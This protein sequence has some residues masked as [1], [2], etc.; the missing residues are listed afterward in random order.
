MT[1]AYF[2]ETQKFR[3][4]WIWLIILLTVVSWGYAL[5]SSLQAEKP[6]KA[7][8]DLVL[9]LTS[10]IP[11]MLILLIL[12]LRLVTRIRKEGIYIQFK[13]LQV[14]EKFIPKEQIKSFEVRKYKPLAEYGGWGIRAGLRKYGKAYNVSG[15]MGL[16]L[17]LE[18]GKKLLI[19]TQKP[20]EIQKAME[21]LLGDGR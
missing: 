3:Q 13:P 20:Q 17:Y 19:G 7:T 18:N 14:R 11:V 9:M 21:A 8:D 12:V 5:I 15:N 4:W 6:D 1:R 10:I 16:Q 2:N